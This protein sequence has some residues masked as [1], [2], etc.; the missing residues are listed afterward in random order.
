MLIGIRDRASSLVAYVIIGLLV[1]SFALWG[2]QEYFGTGGAIVVANVN[3]S[4]IPQ[5]EFNNHLQWYKQQQRTALGDNYALVYPDDGIIKK[6]VLDLMLDNELLSQ[7]VS[8]AGFQVSDSRLIDIIRRLPQF[9]KDGEFDPALYER[10]LRVQRYSKARFEMELRVEEKL[11]Q[12]GSAVVESAFIP[13]GD[14]RHFQRLSEQSRHIEYALITVRPD[15]VSVSPEEIDNYYR[16]NQQL[17]RTP[18]RAR[19]AYIEIKEEALQDNIRIAE[20]DARTIFETQPERYIS[21]ELRKA[22]YILLKVPNDVAA[23]AIEWDEATEQANDL[24][25]QIKEGAAF[26][27]LAMQHSQ[28]ILSAEK[29]GDIGFVAPG[30]LASTELEEALFTLNIG[31]TSEPVRS[32]LGVQMIQLVEIKPAAQKPFEEVQEQIINERKG[33]LAQHRF[34]EITDELANLVAEQPDS[35]QEAAAALDLEIQQTGWLAAGDD[36]DIFAYPKVKEL[37]SSDDILEAELNS[38]LIE[39]AEGH[40]IV[41]RIL[42][43]K[44]PQQ[45]TLQQVSEEINA[46]LTM[47][48]AAEQTAGRGEELL[49]QMKA[50]ASLESL[51]EVH[52]LEIVSDMLR[53]R[54]PSEVVPPRVAERAYRLPRPVA[55]QPQTAGVALP[56]GSFALI[57]LR[58]VVDGAD[59]LDDEDISLLSQQVSYGGRE[60]STIVTAL[61][62]EADI[63][64]FENNL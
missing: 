10:L 46:I 6:E 38:D 34:I 7:R 41:F 55:D 30:D 23:D 1:I 21:P 43:H 26:T 20:Q 61:R 17:Y 5:S 54:Q 19:L 42:E 51:S 22:R 33:Q 16:D 50:G 64:I 11:K 31:E 58:E 62:D 59:Q 63:R 14:L 52:S 40:V 45:K 13:N 36:A 28:D 3:D 8:A 57:E 4:D 2:I 29:G 48:K 37:A 56:D 32:E 24:V 49:A 60:F 47:R 12:F 9:Q 39:V 53:R 35:L 27:D 18:Q 44:P 25:K 15:A